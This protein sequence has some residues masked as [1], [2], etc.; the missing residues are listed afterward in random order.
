MTQKEKGDFL[1]GEWYGRTRFKDTKYPVK[2]L[3]STREWIKTG[4]PP[5]ARE[6]LKSFNFDYDFKRK[7]DKVE[8]YKG[9]AKS[10][11]IPFESLEEYQLYKDCYEDFDRG[12]RIR[13]KTQARKNKLATTSDYE[14]FF[15]YVELKRFKFS[16]VRNVTEKTELRIVANLIHKACGFGIKRISKFLNIPTPT[17]QYWIKTVPISDAEL[18]ARGMDSAFISIIESHFIPSQ[19]LDVVKMKASIKAWLGRKT[20]SVNAKTVDSSST[21]GSGMLHKS[22]ENSHNWEVEIRADMDWN[23]DRVSRKITVS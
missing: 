17:V 8:D 1:L 14:R 10:Q 22:L 11:T 19:G 12:K 16:G 7:P 2:I 23:S 13:G 15:K 4:C 6:E 18:R 9:I 21:N 20:S 3:P 5:V